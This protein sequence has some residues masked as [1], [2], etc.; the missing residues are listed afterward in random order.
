[1]ALLRWKK[2]AG[3]PRPPTGRCLAQL[4]FTVL[5]GVSVENASAQAVSEYELKAAFLYNFAKFVEWPA[6]AFK[7]S[8][9]PIR[10]C[11]AG[12]NPFGR[13]LENAVQGKL[14]EGRGLVVDEIS[15]L[16]QATA[17]HILFVGASERKRVL[18]ILDTAAAGCG[19]L[20]IGDIEGFAAQGG[21]ANFKLEEGRVRFEIN[22]AAAYQQHLRVS[23][24]LLSL[25]K[26]VGK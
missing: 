19:I 2:P 18:T 21:V 7:D 20:S 4:V 1:M 17:C 9:D 8:N 23:S 24:K 26:I 5:A 12:K 3:V 6:A 11:V 13:A 14:I 16:R 15:D 25:A 22:V 10:I